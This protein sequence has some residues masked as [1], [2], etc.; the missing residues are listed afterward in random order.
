MNS[1]LEKYEMNDSGENTLLTDRV[2][3]YATK[4]V[5]A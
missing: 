2:F 4:S 1:V 5:H 3:I